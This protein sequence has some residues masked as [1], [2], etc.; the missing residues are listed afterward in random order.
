M[1]YSAIGILAFLI[2][3]FEHKDFLLKR[4]RI[5]RTPAGKAYR[6]FLFAVFSKTE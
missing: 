5:S 2:L 3:L 1:Y 6:Q 4:N